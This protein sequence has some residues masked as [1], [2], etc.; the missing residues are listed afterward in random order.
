MVGEIQNNGSNTIAAVF[1]SG[2]VYTKDGEAQAYSEGGAFVTHLLPQQKAPFAIEF[3]PQY[4]PTGDLSWLSIGVDHI[5]F[6]IIQAEV[7]YSYQ[8]PDLLV[9]SSSGGVDAEGVYWVSGSVIN[10]GIQI[11]TDVRVIGTFY[12]TSGTVV[13]VGYTYTLTPNPLEPSN[14]ALFKVGAFDLNQTGI[15]AIQKIASYAL[16]IQVEDPILSGT[17]PSLPPSTPSPSD[18]TPLPTPTE[19][20]SSNNS[21]NSNASQQD[22]QYAAVII[23][24]I[25]IVAIIALVGVILFLRMRKT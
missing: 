1:L 13:A 12:N 19:T 18:N 22:V 25:I 10:S 2:I 21:N 17:A 14:T 11:A 6:T 23:A 8:Y 7:V 9:Q 24:A 5:E 16:L 20:P 15:A 4:S 3:L